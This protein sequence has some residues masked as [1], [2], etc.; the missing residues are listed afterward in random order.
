MS[1]LA[2]VGLGLVAAPAAAAGKTLTIGIEQEPNGF[3]AVKG[4][5]LGEAP[6]SVMLTMVDRLMEPPFDNPKTRARDPP[7]RCPTTA[8][9]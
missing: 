8:R 9:Q 2:L 3:D 6:A 4:R 7:S 5:V 1:A